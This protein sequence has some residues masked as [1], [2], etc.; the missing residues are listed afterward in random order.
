MQSRRAT[1][2]QKCIV[3]LN[4]SCTWLVNI[5]QVLSDHFF[6]F[7]Q[8]Q[9]MRLTRAMTRIISRDIGVKASL[10]FCCSHLRQE[11]ISLD[12][13]RSQESKSFKYYLLRISTRWNNYS[14]TP[15]DS[16]KLTNYRQYTIERFCEMS[17]SWVESR[18][19][20]WQSEERYKAKLICEEL[21]NLTRL[22]KEKSDVRIT[23]FTNYIQLRYIH[24]NNPIE[25]KH[26][27][28]DFDGLILY[29][30]ATFRGPLDWL[31]HDET[32][33]NI[34]LVSV[35]YEAL[36]SGVLVL[37]GYDSGQRRSE[38]SAVKLR[39][40]IQE[41]QL[42]RYK[43]NIRQ[44]TFSKLKGCLVRTPF[45]S[46]IYVH[47]QLSPKEREWVVFHELGHFLFHHRP[48][49]E[50]ALN[51]GR[52]LSNEGKT[53]SREEQEANGFADLW[54]HVLKGLVNHVL[55]NG[56]ARSSEQQH[57]SKDASGWATAAKHVAAS[58]A[59]SR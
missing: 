58:A 3:F 30:A 21:I 31:G 50:H 49:S 23:Q 42:L 8:I 57:A 14:S 39:R 54:Q 6:F 47:D 9:T 4:D 33:Y 45:G 55:E 22:N 10:N 24:E 25:V 38:E 48:S 15:T 2:N 35:I 36:R 20:V 51:Q 13:E 1:I 27:H 37:G 11:L 5:P 17:L 41:G 46:S 16:Q 29:L 44:T 19:E 28:R 40:Q 56:S 7:N 52:I 26:D 32:T 43:L 34:L 18:L 53:W 59:S 12:W